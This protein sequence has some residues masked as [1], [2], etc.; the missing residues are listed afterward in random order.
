MPQHVE[1]EVRP[2]GFALVLLKREPV[3]LMDLTMWQQLMAALEGLEAD[4][5]CMPSEFSGAVLAGLPWCCLSGNALASL[6]SRCGGSSCKHWESLDQINYICIFVC[7]FGRRDKQCSASPL[8][9]LLQSCTS[10]EEA[11]GLQRVRGVIFASG[12][13]RQVFTAGNDIK[14]LY[15]PQTSIARH[16]LAPLP[17]LSSHAIY[18]ST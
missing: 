4:Q 17:M 16:A 12:L 11:L 5:V 7:C 14:E 3:N 1:V 18:C 10:T 9:K 15:A 13:Q 8:N 6:T 2:G